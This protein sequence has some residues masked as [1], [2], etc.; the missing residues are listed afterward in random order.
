MEA[1]IQMRTDL[2]MSMELGDVRGPM[3]RVRGPRPS[4]PWSLSGYLSVASSL[5]L[6]TMVSGCKP[7]N[8][9]APPPPPEVTVAHPIRMQVTRYLEYTGTTEAY[10]S[11][12]LRA[13]VPGFLDEI[14]FKPGGRVQTG[15]L[16]FVIDKR[17]F[18]AAVD[19]VQAQVLSDEAS[20]QSAE[21]N[22]RL[23]EEL[24]AQRAGSEIDRI[25]KVG[26]RDAARAA[27]E[28]SRAA[29]ETAK[30][31][32]EFCE[33]RAPIDGR[34]TKNFLDL[35]NY[36]GAGGQPTVLATL[37]RSR[38]IYVSVDASESDLLEVRRSRI[39]RDPSLEPGQIS[40]GQWRPVDL[41][42]AGDAEFRVHGVIDYVDPALNPQTGT[43][44]VR[45]R[46]DNE[47]E[48]LLPGIFVR[49]RILLGS[50]EATV[51][52]DI[53]LLSDQAGRYALVVNDKNIVEIRRVKIGALDGPMRVVAEGLST[54]D[55]IVV[56]GL[57]RARPGATVKPTSQELSAVAAPTTQSAVPPSAP[58]TQPGSTNR[59][60]ARDSAPTDPPSRP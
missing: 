46:F 57:Q 54:S 51:V 36:V 59:P 38:P 15:D 1:A 10:Q 28:A 30:L 8:T 26:A 50:S 6:I 20:L 34:I 45:C 52:P 17:T 60:S 32:L 21:A 19:Q 22:A 58:T 40:P 16:L 41:A 49:L 55:Q 44:R 56:N 42:L 48:F 53:A 13:R 29:L 33:V 39:D 11:V 4:G 37:V 43:I 27:V 7:S 35:G 47:D 25:T 31:N 9:Y 3:T 2:L 18:Q 5:L 14:H 12:D 24:A 23:A